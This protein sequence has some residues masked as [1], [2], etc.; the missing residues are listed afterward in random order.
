M[1]RPISPASSSSSFFPLSFNSSFLLFI[2]KRLSNWK[3][4]EIF[5]HTIR[6]IDFW[7]HSSQTDGEIL[8]W[9]EN[10]FPSPLIRV[11]KIDS[12]LYT[13]QTRESCYLCI[14][15]DMKQSKKRGD[16]QMRN[17]KTQSQRIPYRSCVN[18]LWWVVAKPHVVDGTWEVLM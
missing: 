11:S 16:M 8:L 17:N 10:E 3:K 18:T 9:R 15:N 14:I 5:T 2:F 13:K 4:E 12:R 1:L 7:F 6:S